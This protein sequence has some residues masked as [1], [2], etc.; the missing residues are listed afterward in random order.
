MPERPFSLLR[1]ALPFVQLRLPAVYRVEAIQKALDLQ[2]VE[3]INLGKG[4][5]GA[6][7]SALLANQIV[8]RFKLAAMRRGDMSPREIEDFLLYVDECHNWPAENFMELLSEARKYRM[9][10]ILA[11][12]YTAQLEKKGGKGG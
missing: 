6:T 4:R 2:A 9:G 11:T 7:I 10:L 1:K 5:F 12:Q 3:L 8:S